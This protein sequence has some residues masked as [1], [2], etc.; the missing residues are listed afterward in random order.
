MPSLTAPGGDDAGPFG[1]YLRGM[2]GTSILTLVMIAIGAGILHALARRHVD[3]NLFS[4]SALD[5]SRLTRC[6][7]GASRPNAAWRARWS[8]P[9][10]QRVN[11][12]APS[13]ADQARERVLPIRE[14]DPLTGDDPGDDVALRA[15]LI[16]RTSDND[17]AY[18]GPHLLFN[19]TLGTAELGGRSGARESFVLS[20]LYCGSRSVGYARTENSRPADA[21]SPNLTLGRALAIS[22]APG[23]TR[24]GS[25][26]PSP[27]MALLT[28]FSSRPGSWIEKPKSDG[29]GAASPRF[30]D[31]PVTTALGLAG[32]GGKFVYLTGGEEF[33]RLGVYE[34]IRRRCRYIVAVDGGA[35]SDAGLA[36]LIGR[37]RIEFGLRV[38]IDRPRRLSSACVTIGQ[39]H[40]GDVDHGAMPGV[41]V[42]VG[43]SLSDDDPPDV[44]QYTQ[45]ETFDGA[46]FE[47]SRSQGEHA[48][49]VVFA[50]V[51]T[52]LGAQTS[53]LAC[54]PQLEFAPRL[55]EAIVEDWQRAARA[56]NEVILN[57]ATT[58]A[59][60]P[61]AEGGHRL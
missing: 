26:Q 14:P 11:V 15:L 16:G 41:I 3:V 42:Y 35:A 4:L 24:M 28:L 54:L 6:Y 57:S 53:D 50:E 56:D 27:L 43:P 38:E 32:G 2:D 44:N 18:W 33:E 51:V 31:L 48:A 8:Q 20:P 19:T 47:C 52:R 40:Y 13:L 22:G 49:R 34:L 45:D 25:V 17:R 39:V 7:L 46:Q 37:C 61:D 21:D 29:W 23:N 5:T 60:G 12:G 9:R 59:T 1:Y 58:A 30:G 10:D 36:T 55:F